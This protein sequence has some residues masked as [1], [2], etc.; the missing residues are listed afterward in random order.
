MS[1]V[2]LSLTVSARLDDKD[3][4]DR[5]VLDPSLKTF[6]K[7]VTKAG[8][9]ELLKA[10]AP[11][12]V[13][14]PNDAAFAKLPPGALDA[15]MK[16][17]FLLRKTIGLHILTGKLLVKDFKEGSTKT[18]SGDLLPFKFKGGLTIGGAKIMVSDIP[19]SNG[20]IHVVNMVLMPPSKPTR[21][22]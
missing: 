22:P 18:L 7:L 10:D 11:L 19:A 12:T 16:D 20:T 5:L 1:C 2:L 15:L 17:K 21:I 9:I 4:I 6:T 13:F 14:A 3:L 8:L